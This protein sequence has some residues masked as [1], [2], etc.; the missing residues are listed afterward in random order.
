MP[1]TGHFY[2]LALDYTADEQGR[3]KNVNTITVRCNHCRH[4]SRAEAGL[5]PISGGTLLTCGKC[6]AR[7]AVSNARLVECDHILSRGGDA[8]SAIER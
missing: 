6:G 8:P 1:D 2:V 5:E 7:Q 4:V 3:I